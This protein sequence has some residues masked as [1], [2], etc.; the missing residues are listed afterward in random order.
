VKWRRSLSVTDLHG[1][2]NGE[3]SSILESDLNEFLLAGTEEKVKL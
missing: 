2:M 1:V 3:L